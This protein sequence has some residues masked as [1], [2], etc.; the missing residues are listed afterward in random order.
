M[1]MMMMMTP[2]FHSHTSTHSSPSTAITA[3]HEGDDG[4]QNC[5]NAIDDGG[6]D[7]ADAMDN[8]HQ[9]VADGCKDGL[10]L[11]NP[12]SIKW[13]GK[14]RI[15]RTQDRTAPILNLLLRT[16]FSLFV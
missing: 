4:V 13:Y 8:G 5:D 14:R 12:V 16:G 6:E 3:C 15:K 11:H 1:M 7:G 9:A 10:K 2:S